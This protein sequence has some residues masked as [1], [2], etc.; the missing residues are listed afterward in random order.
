MLSEKYDND[1]K[2]TFISVGELTDDQKEAIADVTKKLESGEYAVEVVS[3]CCGSGNF[4]LLA[5]KDRYGIPCDTVICRE[6]GLIQLN[7]RMTP[8]AYNRFYNDEYRRLDTQKPWQE[9]FDLQYEQG[10]AVSEAVQNENNINILEVGCYTGG[11]LKALSD[12]GHNCIGIDI[13]SDIIAKS[14]NK[15]DLNLFVGSIDSLDD[16][17]NNM[18]DLVV[19]KQVFEHV[20]HPC[21]ELL[22]IYRVLSDGGKLLIN[23]PSLLSL[24]KGVV[25]NGYAIFPF[26]AFIQLAHPYGYVGTT[27]TYLLNNNRFLLCS[28]VETISGITAVFEKSVSNYRKVMEFLSGVEEKLKYA[29]TEDPVFSKH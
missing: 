26:T 6:C 2:S 1:Y 8:E 29:N 4:N 21:K 23:V 18:V 9:M 17:F 24:D 7:P 11:A 28:I 5:K 13:D 19:Y 20:L 12:K 25:D 14:K 15:T 27:L 10:K 3:C 22:H 16:S